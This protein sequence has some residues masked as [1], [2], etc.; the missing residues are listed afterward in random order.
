MF[1]YLPFCWFLYCII[2]YLSIRETNCNEIHQQTF[3]KIKFL[4]PKWIAFQREEKVIDNDVDAI[5]MCAIFCSMTQNCGGSIYHND[6][7]KKGISK[8]L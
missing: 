4:K 5:L 3:K 8:S 7:G 6:L 1:Y 2:H